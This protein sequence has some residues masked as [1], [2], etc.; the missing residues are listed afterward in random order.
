[1]PG[2]VGEKLGPQDRM[3][4]A[5]S[6]DLTVH[7][8]ERLFTDDAVSGPFVRV[9]VWTVVIGIPEGSELGNLPG[10]TGLTDLKTLAIARLMLDNIAHIKAFWIATGVEVAQVGLW[11]GVDDLDGTVQ[12]EKIYHMAGARTPETLTTASMRAK[13]IAPHVLSRGSAAA[14][15]FSPVSGK[16]GVLA[17]PQRGVRSMLPPLVS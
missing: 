6:V 10:P 2:A 11:F 14:R 7:L 17:P 8:Y 1:M 16:A 9:F 15:A 13:G 5:P 12:E 4:F 3:W